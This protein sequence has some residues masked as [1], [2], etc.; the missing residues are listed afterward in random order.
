MVTYTGFTDVGLR[1][2][3][4]AVTGVCRRSLQG[5]GLQ[6]CR[7]LGWPVRPGLLSGN[8]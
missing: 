4:V 8:T 1:V 3:R 5:S 2:C 6:D 7:G